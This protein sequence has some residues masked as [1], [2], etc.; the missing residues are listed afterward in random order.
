MSDETL[1]RLV[2]EAIAEN[3]SPLLKWLYGVFASVILGTALLVG[4]HYE[5]LHDIKM[6]QRLAL[7]AKQEISEVKTSVE[8]VSTLVLLHDRQIGIYEDR[9][10][11]S[12][13]E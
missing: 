5:A 1:S 13:G 11:K 9:S 7:E 12:G 10:R 8:K 2:I 3:L 4:I 6:A